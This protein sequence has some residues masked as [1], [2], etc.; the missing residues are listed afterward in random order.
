M[1]ESIN[2]IR[3]H[4]E[5]YEMHMCTGARREARGGRGQA[6]VG[7]AGSR[8]PGDRR[9]AGGREGYTGR[10]VGVGCPGLAGRVHRASRGS[11]L[12]G[13]NVVRPTVSHQDEGEY[14]C[15]LRGEEEDKEEKKEKR[16]AA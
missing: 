15:T 2:A 8:R 14:V 4:V 6:R 10:A 12:P 13:G 5:V 3:T 16:S 1:Q 9:P 11:G 7:R